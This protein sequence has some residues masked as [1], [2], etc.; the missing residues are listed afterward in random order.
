MAKLLRMVKWTQK[1]F[2]GAASIISEDKATLLPMH[3]LVKLD[4]LRVNMYGSGM[5]LQTFHYKPF[6]VS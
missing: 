3:W 6:Y 5:S 1:G 2:N 4:L